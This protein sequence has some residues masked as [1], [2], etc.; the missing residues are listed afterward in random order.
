MMGAPLQDKC[1]HLYSKQKMQKETWK[2]IAG[3]EGHYEVSSLGRI[4][5]FR[6]G[7]AR[8]ADPLIK[9][10]QVVNSGYE[11]VLLRSTKRRLVHHLVLEAFVGQRPNGCEAAHL[12]GDRLDNRLENLIW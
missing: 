10:S 3:Y 2:S 5:T 12:N 11:T 9:K 6:N 1:L 7:R 8:L 4:R